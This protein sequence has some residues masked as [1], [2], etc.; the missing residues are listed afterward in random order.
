VHDTITR[1][2]D[3]TIIEPSI[4]NG[5]ITTQLHSAFSFISRT[6]YAIIVSH[7]DPVYIDEPQVHETV[8]AK[9]Q[10]RYGIDIVVV[11]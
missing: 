5:A 2:I 8:I 9:K 7:T 4:G 11:Q 6:E 10:L 1:S 3:E